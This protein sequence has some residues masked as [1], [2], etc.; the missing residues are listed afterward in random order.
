M[1]GLDLSTADDL[2]LQWVKYFDDLLHPEIIYFIHVEKNFEESAY[3]PDE[4]RSIQALDEKMIQKLHESVGKYFSTDSKNI[5]IEA[6]EGN[7]F[8]TLV[9][10]VDVKK[11]DLFIA[12]IKKETEGRGILPHMLSR[13][14]HCPVLFI[15]QVKQH[16][17]QRAL[18][19]LDFSEHS[20][21]ALQSAIQLKKFIP[22]LQLLCLH[23]YNIPLGYYKIGKTYE[24]FREIMKMNAE[25]KFHRFTE[26]FSEELSCIFELQTL[27]NG[28]LIEKTAANRDSDLVFLGSKGQTNSSVLLLGS[29][30]EKV[31]Q[32]NKHCLTWVVKKPGENIGFFQAIQ[33]MP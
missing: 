16:P 4:Y 10:W 30:T 9:H 5:Q 13:K 19:P 23:I 12:G 11:V 8:D 2:I 17:I 7:P 26:E 1:V 20:K 28:A 25:K 32:I 31:I 6:I 14:L 29:T 27:T 24:Q 21:L 18:I 15:P 3:L 33:E 22:Q